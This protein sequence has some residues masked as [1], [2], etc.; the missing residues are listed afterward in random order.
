MYW[1]WAILCIYTS[2]SHGAQDKVLDEVLPP[3]LNKRISEWVQLNK[4]D[5]VLLVQTTGNCSQQKWVKNWA[6]IVDKD[7]Q[8]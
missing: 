5:K 8:V 7:K 2:W 6:R 3:A 1:K 4:H